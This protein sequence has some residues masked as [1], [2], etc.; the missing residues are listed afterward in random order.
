MGHVGQDLRGKIGT[1]IIGGEKGGVDQRRGPHGNRF[2]SLVADQ[3]GKADI[4]H[5]AKGGGGIQGVSQL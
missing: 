5:R 4:G 1:A 3:L 2:G